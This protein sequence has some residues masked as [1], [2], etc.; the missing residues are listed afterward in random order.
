[1]PLVT[2]R[3]PNPPRAYEFTSGPY[4]GMHDSLDP[5]QARPELAKYIQN[6]LPYHREAGEVS[7]W[8]GR[9]GSTQVHTKA[10][11][12]R[13]QCVFQLSKLDGTEVS[14]WIV[15]GEIYTYNH[16]TDTA[17]KVVSTADLTTASAALDDSNGTR[18]FACQFGD[19]IVFSDGVNV[20]V[21][22]DG[23]SGDSGITPL[24]DCPVLY[25]APVVYFGRLVGIKNT[26]R[27]VIVWSEVADATTGY[28]AGFNNTAQLRQTAQEPVFAL[29][30]TNS[31]LYY[32]RARSIGGLFGPLDE[33]SSTSTTEAV[34]E[35]IGTSS[36]AGVWLYKDRI[37]FVDSD[38]RPH[39][40][41]LGGG[42]RPCHEGFQETL[43]GIGSTPSSLRYAIT[44][45]RP[46][47]EH[48][49][50][51]L[52][53]PSGLTVRKWLVVDPDSLRATSVFLCGSSAS[54]AEFTLAAGIWKDSANR[55]RFITGSTN[56]A[57]F[58]SGLLS[59]D[60][61]TASWNDAI[62]SGSDDTEDSIQHYIE[63]SPVAADGK[64]QKRFD[65]MD[66]NLFIQERDSGESFSTIAL[67]YRTNRGQSFPITGA[68]S[69][70]PAS[71]DE[72]DAK[73]VVGLNAFGRWI[74]PIIR[75]ITSRERFGFRS[76]VLTGRG[77]E[78]GPGVR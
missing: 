8:V 40:F 29:A 24:D 41:I 35:E 55:P 57:V 10:E 60:G 15:D 70:A 12:E 11:G 48:V 28:E 51:G 33:F 26:E 19:E 7:A 23:S 67:G 6:M 61:A 36:P 65:R 27:N 22:W 54:P 18:I 31:T 74:V 71:T 69:L 3:K 1:M 46:D 63:G 78:G 32:F 30:A 2:M 75:H 53:D 17:T 45:Y 58:M 59:A 34:S 13:V 39:V 9:P 5:S 72:E 68:T 44:I 21:M 47:I 73:L 62:S 4:V 50:F 38:A 76:F 37:F 16:G 77:L 42:V 20:P 43:R 52:P 66:A 56:R 25:G 64:Y 49:V 14:G